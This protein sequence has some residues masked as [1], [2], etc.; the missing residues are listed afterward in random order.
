MFQIRSEM[1]GLETSL[2]SMSGSSNSAKTYWV[3]PSRDLILI[4]PGM[5][6]KALAYIDAYRKTDPVLNKLI[7]KLDATAYTEY[8]GILASCLANWVKIAVEPDRELNDVY[9][10]YR[11]TGFE[12]VDRAMM[13]AFNH[14]FSR[15][16]LSAY[17][18]FS[19]TAKLGTFVPFDNSNPSDVLDAAPMSL[20]VLLRRYLV[21]KLKRR[22]KRDGV[23]AGPRCV[24]VCP[25]V[26]EKNSQ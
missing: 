1:K 24:S 15:V 9:T 25:R 6:Q 5:F 11:D 13:A 19:N 26:D 17:Y 20:R 23:C 2:K 22:L 18:S 16:I 12:A 10:D 8:A 3:S 14:S 4:L 7:G 21:A